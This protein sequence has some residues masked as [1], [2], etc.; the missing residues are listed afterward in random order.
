MFTVFFGDI[1]P[2]GQIGWLWWVSNWHCQYF[3]LW[4]LLTGKIVRA[5]GV[6]RHD[7]TFTCFIILMIILAL[8][9]HASLTYRGAWLHKELKL[10]NY[11]S[12]PALPPHR[13]SELL[14]IMMIIKIMAIGIPL[15][16]RWRG[17][18]EGFL[19]TCPQARHSSAYIGCLIVS[20]I[21][22]KKVV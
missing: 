19:G 7:D 21:F 6:F 10:E 15:Q 17:F 14:F 18:Q 2:Q 20:E 16:W 8:F 13:Q 22:Q 5:C 1:F 11:R 12:P 9:V 3:S 4:N